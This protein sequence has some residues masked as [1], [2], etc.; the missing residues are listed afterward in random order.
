[1]IETAAQRSAL[2][3]IALVGLGALC[4]VVLVG[5]TP[6][7]EV[8]TALKLVTVV[9]AAAAIGYYVVH[10]PARADRLDLAVLAAVLLFAVAGIFSQHLRQSLDAV[11]A[12]LAW[13]CALFVARDGTT[14]RGPRSPPRG[15]HGAICDRHDHDGDPMAAG[16]GD[17]VVFNGHR[18]S[19]ARP[20]L[21]R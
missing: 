1:M 20:R 14:T 7:G 11:L 9:I 12:A 8:T 19:A 4:Y 2:G 21:F 13:A 3:P 16:R 15:A 6:L 18:C 10:G 5:G 17:M